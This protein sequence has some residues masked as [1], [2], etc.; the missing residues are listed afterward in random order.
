MLTSSTACRYYYLL[1]GEPPLPE[2]DTVTTDGA[3]AS[4]TVNE[5][6][7]ETNAAAAIFCNIDRNMDG[8]LTFEELQC[9]LSDF[10]VSEEEIEKIF[11]RFDTTGDGVTLEQFEAALTS[12]DEINTIHPENVPIKWLMVR[13]LTLFLLQLPTRSNCSP[14]RMSQQKHCHPQAARTKQ[15]TCGHL[16]MSCEG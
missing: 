12:W 9:R 6:L 7:R 1:L 11:L 13:H 10:G 5:L 14:C 15:G 16:G 3:H 4:A 8:V 2:A